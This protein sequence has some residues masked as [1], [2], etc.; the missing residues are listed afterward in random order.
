LGSLNRLKSAAT[1]E[2]PLCS[3]FLDL[4][5]Q[6]HDL[7]EAQGELAQRLR[8]LQSCL[9]VQPSEE[10]EDQ[11]MWLYNLT[12]PF[13]E[14]DMSWQLISNDFASEMLRV[15]PIPEPWCTFT[16]NPIPWHSAD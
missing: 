9:M 12:I 14:A 4:V 2:R 15:L 8:E 16:L 11:E 7:N 5:V 1:T 6:G 13:N 10:R 3:F